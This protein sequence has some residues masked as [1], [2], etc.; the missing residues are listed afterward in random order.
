MLGEDEIQKSS[1]DDKAQDLW[2]EFRENH[3]LK[4]PNS[5]IVFSPSTMFRDF[6]WCLWSHLRAPTKHHLP[7]AQLGSSHLAF[8]QLSGKAYQ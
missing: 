3:G 1:N 8:P 4:V 6:F 5:D 2:G 7:L